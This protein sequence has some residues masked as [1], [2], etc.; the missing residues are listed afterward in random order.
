MRYPSC[1]DA[2][3]NGSSTLWA[4]GARNVSVLFYATPS[5]LSSSL[6]EFIGNGGA[7]S[8]VHFIGCLAAEGA[9][10]HRRIVLD[11][12]ELDESS[13]CSYVVE[14]VDVHGCANTLPMR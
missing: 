2:F 4:L 5:R 1:G 13:Q 7:A 11:Y 6:V 12:V 3:T 10:R 9:V 14:M 8:E